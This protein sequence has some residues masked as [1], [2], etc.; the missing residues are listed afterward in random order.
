MKSSLVIGVILIVLGAAG[1]AYKS[2][3][4]TTEETVAQLGSLKA[5][6]EVENEIAIPDILGIVSIIA[7][8]LIIAV[9]SKR[10]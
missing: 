8:V 2:F 4:Y 7:G 6:A 5:T 9:G 3:S 10:N 1:L